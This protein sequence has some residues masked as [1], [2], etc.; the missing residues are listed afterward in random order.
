VLHY[1][2]WH[3]QVEVFKLLLEKGADI[4][5][6]TKFYLHT[7]L[8]YASHNGHVEVVQLLLEKGADIAQQ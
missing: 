5:A 6:A 3:G 1:A 8:H 7:P 2:S 4:T